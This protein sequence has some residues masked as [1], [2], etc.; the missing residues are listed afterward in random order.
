MKKF[1]MKEW[2]DRGIT[3]VKISFLEEG[4]GIK[5]AIMPKNEVREFLSESEWF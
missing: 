3:K 2:D 1:T 4:K 5:E